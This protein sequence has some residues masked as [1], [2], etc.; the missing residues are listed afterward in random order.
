MTRPSKPM[1]L[2]HPAAER[3]AAA[4]LSAPGFSR[5]VER[6]AIEADLGIKAHAHTCCATPA[7]TSLPTTVTIRGDSG[8]P[9]SP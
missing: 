6:A 9:R 8:V 4:M 2:L 7:A 3:A 1:L 5:M